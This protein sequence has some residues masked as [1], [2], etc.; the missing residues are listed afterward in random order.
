MG[1]AMDVP[2]LD[3]GMHIRRVRRGDLDDINTLLAE[4]DLALVAAER[5]AL[6]RFRNIVAD[7]GCDFDVAIRRERVRGFV[8]VTYARDLLLG[9]RANLV[10]L[11]GASA[12]VRTA[13]LAVATARA[14]RRRCVDITALAG[15]WMTVDP[16]AASPDWRAAT[17]RWR[18]PLDADDGDLP[19]N[20][21][22]CRG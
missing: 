18:L 14:R 4:T 16:S 21:Q 5:A 10:A 22:T 19:A 13:L 7:L 8:H 6:R 1:V 17:G 2:N 11:V 12:G 9:N 3:A 15:P 20:T